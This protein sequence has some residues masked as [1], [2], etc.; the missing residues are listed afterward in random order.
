MRRGTGL[1]PECH[2]TGTLRLGEEAEMGVTIAV[3]NES[4]V[5]DPNE[6]ATAWVPALQTQVSRDFAPIWGDD[7]SLVFVAGSAAPPPD[8]WQLVVLDDSDQANALGYHDLTSNGLPIGKVF[9]RSDQ[10]ANSQVSV[11]CSHELLEML[12]D[13]MIVSTVMFDD[14]QGNVAAF[15]LEVCDTCEADDYGYDISGTLVSDFVYPSWFGARPNPQG[16]APEALDAGGHVGVALN[17]ADPASAILPGGY[18]GMWQPPGGWTQLTGA[19]RVGD[20]FAVAQRGSRRERRNRHAQWIRSLPSA[21]IAE[22]RRER[23]TS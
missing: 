10:L 14:G 23:V 22:R 21:T 19:E 1:C 18:I 3:I 17:L 15:A 7:A 9:A 13:P 12:V 8:A 5:V 20:P 11:T 6:V 16:V 2:G 4:T